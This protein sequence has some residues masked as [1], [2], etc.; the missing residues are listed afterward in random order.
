MSATWVPPRPTYHLRV[1]AISLLVVVVC[2]AAFLFGVRLEAVVPA[3]GIV[4]ARD[5]IE[6]R[7]LLPGLVEPGWYEG[8]VLLPGTGAVPVRLDAH[9]DG[10]SDPA[11]SVTLRLHHHE[12]RVEGQR[13]R[14][15]N[16]RFHRLEPGDEIWS[17]Q[18]LASIRN[19]ELRSRMAQIED[20]LREG[21]SRGETN[22][23]LGRERDRV[24]E[25][26]AQSALHTPD[27]GDRWLVLQVQAAPLQ[28]V[29]AGDV[30]ATVVP[31]DPQ[32]HQPRNLVARLD[33]AEQYFGDLAVGQAV[34]LHSTMYNY[35]LHG[36]AMGRI[37]RLEPWG[38]P[39]SDGQRR[40]HASA[41]ITEAP[42]A[43]PIG[44]TFKARVVV[45]RK[46]VYRIILEH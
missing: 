35:R 42:F 9:G 15:R 44:S 3:T 45:G 8:E 19:D 27:G 21:E 23:S 33:V 32:T 11:D 30:I 37:D 7:A 1:L 22:G 46:L 36:A 40:F 24:R 29:Q 17:G 5:L 28:P 2:L 12:C 34:Q 4:T 10:G 26:L 31:I 18:V 25:R 39:A 16:V 43:L 13:L 38:E 6:V 20:Q 41:A 14:A